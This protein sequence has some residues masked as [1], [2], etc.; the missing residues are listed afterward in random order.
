M[1][2][3]KEDRRVQRTRGMLFEALMDLIVEKGYDAITIQD[4]IDRANIGR[5]TFYSHFLDKEQLLLENVDQLREFLKEQRVIPSSQGEPGEYRFGFSLAMIQH[6]QSHKLIFRAVAGKQSGVL[7][8]Y[9]IKRML[10][11]IAREEIA[12]FLPSSTPPIIPQ[13]VATE[14]VVNTFWS[15]VT[16]WMEQSRPYS[17]K[18]I[19]QM[20]HKL[21]LSG[22]SALEN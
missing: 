6:V 4:I 8:I 1:T 20:F 19:D 21:A 22:I 16:W 17:A 10:T 15:I 7:V 3:K 2:A 11:E 14:F 5:S 13:E 9:H 12:A 18:E